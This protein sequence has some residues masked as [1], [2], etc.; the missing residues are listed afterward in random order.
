M[1][2]TAQE[3]MQRLNEA[4]AGKRQALELYA[5][6]PNN[7]EAH[8]ALLQYDL[9]AVYWGNYLEHIEKEGA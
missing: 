2:Y 7:M 6:N 4:K 8:S 9:D 5:S 3:A 1:R